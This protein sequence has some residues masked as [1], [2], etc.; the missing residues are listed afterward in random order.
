MPPS[1]R[2]RHCIYGFVFKKVLMPGSLK[3]TT[4]STLCVVCSLDKQCRRFRD[5]SL[6]QS[7][8]VSVN[9][10]NIIQAQWIMLICHDGHP[11]DRWI[12][13]PRVIR[14]FFH[15]KFKKTPPSNVVRC[16]ISLL[17]SDLQ[18]DRCNWVLGSTSI[19]TLPSDLFEK[20]RELD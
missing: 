2:P 12:M 8:L 16:A 19:Q 15:S 17:V 5:L 11:T 3:H 14:T 6:N 7:Q 20:F 1:Q 4:I 13:W 10:K 18:Y 9:V